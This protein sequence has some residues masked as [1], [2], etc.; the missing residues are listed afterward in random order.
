MKGSGFLKPLFN[1]R[2]TPIHYLQGRFVGA[3]PPPG[4]RSSLQLKGS[5]EQLETTATYPTVWG[6]LPVRTRQDMRRGVRAQRPARKPN[7]GGPVGYPNCARCSTTPVQRGPAGLAM[8]RPTCGAGSGLPTAPEAHSTSRMTA[9][10][11]TS[12]SSAGSGI[13]LGGAGQ[14]AITAASA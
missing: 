5:H 14:Q 11:G 1:R 2:E 9:P 10:S 3:R 6:A 12:P 8:N 7:H 13:T 4:G